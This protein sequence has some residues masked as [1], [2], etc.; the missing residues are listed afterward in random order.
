MENFK[1]EKTD[2]P[3]TGLFSYLE[4]F[5]SG[6]AG[7]NFNYQSDEHLIV[8]TD[9]NYLKTIMHNLT[10]NSIK[11]LMKTADAAIVWKAWKEN[12]QFKLS[13]SDNGRGMSNDQIKKFEE[14]AV[15]SSS[16]HG[17]GLNL[18]KDMAQ[19][20]GCTITLN[21]KEG[22]GTTFTLTIGP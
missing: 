14:G 17:L 15:I 10:Q 12:N 7:I 19:T 5:F 18:V 4:D 22:A 16:R 3:V 20:I 2:V 13:I 9:E 6:T 11:A 21:S 1:P 8:H